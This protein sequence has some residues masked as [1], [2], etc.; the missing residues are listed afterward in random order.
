MKIGIAPLFQNIEDSD[1]FEAMSRGEAAPSPDD[2]RIFREQ[3]GLG[4]LAEPL[5]YDSLW[6]FEHRASSYMLLPNPQQMIA[7]FA[8]RTSRIDFGSMVTVIPWHHPVRLAE[9]IA[10]LQ[11][12][13]GPNRRFVMGTGRGLARR[14]YGSLAI[15]MDESRDRMS[16]GLEIL[17]RAFTGERFSFEGKI[18]QFPSSVVRPRPLDLSFLDD[19]YAVWTSEESMR[20]AAEMGL[21]PLTIP[22]KSMEDY[23]KD[24]EQ[25]DSIRSEYGFGPSKSPI[26]QVYMYCDE[27]GDKARE[28]GIF[29]AQEYA[30]SVVPHYELG[31][32]H[33]SQLKN[34]KSY[35][36]GQKSFFGSGDTDPQAE[37]RNTIAKLLQDEGIY[38]TPSECIERVEEIAKMMHP[39]EIVLVC[40]YGTMK[41]EEAARSLTLFAEK[42][43]PSI[44]KMSLEASA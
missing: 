26:L 40:C 13:L 33:F 30:A 21:N 25:Y 28:K 6:T 22:T 31:G 8:G 41:A 12:M 10:L 23:K 32:S 37:A 2:A 1:R 11:H 35:V 17:R 5:G 9:N 38:G 14:E 24:L 34:Y 16:E 36:S 43:L 44:R 7:Y 3:L 29:H 20:F 18:Y 39:R 4:D 42:V 27:D 15:D 19:I